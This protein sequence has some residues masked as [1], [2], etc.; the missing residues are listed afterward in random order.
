M[1]PADKSQKSEPIMERKESVAPPVA[2]PHKPN[3]FS[4]MLA[5]TSSAFT[6]EYSIFLI[7]LGVTLSNLAGFVYVLFS[8][9]VDA[10]HGGASG[11]MVATNMFTLWL[12]ISS[13]IMLPL[14][15]VLWT[16]T[17]G[18]LAANDDY[19]GELPKGA[20]KGFRTFWII[21]A[22][23]GMAGLLMAAIYAPIAAAVGGGSAT[24]VL[25]S[26]TVP[27]LINVAI[28]GAGIYLVTRGLHE[29]KKSRLIVWTVA[30][31]TAVLFIATYVWASN[32]KTT[33]PSRNTPY[34]S[35]YN[36]YDPYDD[37]YDDPY[38]RYNSPSDYR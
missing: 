14:A 25:L 4:G 1:E 15:V 38:Y 21:L 28:S 33:T 8:L 6:A 20:A 22:A 9:V 26:V 37:L 31:L 24:D 19:K 16:R 12:L 35:P 29:R 10:I 17:Q 34:T 13:A 7:A 3:R 36:D 32:M 11:S 23:L 2:A 18:E 5:R 27:S 30:G